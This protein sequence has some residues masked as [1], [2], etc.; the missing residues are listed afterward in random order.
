MIDR[1]GGLLAGTLLGLLAVWMLAVAALHQPAL[2]MRQVVQRSAILPPLVADLPA[3]PLMDA[4]QRFDRLPVIAGAVG[5]DLPPPDPTL[6]KRPRVAAAIRTSPRSRAAHAA[7]SSPDRA[8]S[9]AAALVATN[10]HVIAGE[11]DTEVEIDAVYWDQHVKRSRLRHAAGATLDHSP[12][13][14]DGLITDLT[15]R[16]GALIVVWGDPA[17]ALLEDVDPQRAGRDHLPLTEAVIAAV[18]SGDLAWTMVAA[19]TPGGAEALLGTPDIERMWELLTPMLRLDAPDPAAAWAEHVATLERRAQAMAAR[20]FDAL[21]FRGGG[22]DLTVGLLPGARWM[23]GGLETSMGTRTVANMPTEEVFTTPHLGRTEGVVRATRPV[24][25]TGGGL[26][27]GLELRFEGG[28]V[29]DVRR[30]ARR[31]RAARA[32]GLGPGG[33]SAWAR[34]RS[35][36]ARRGGPHRH[37]VRRLLIDE[38][39]TSHIAWGHAYAF[40]VPDLPEDA[41]AQA[42]LGF[43]RS[44]VHQDAMIG[45]SRSRSTAS[46]GRRGGAGH[47]RR[48]VGARVVA[49]DRVRPGA[50]RAGA[51]TARGESAR[52]VARPAGPGF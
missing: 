20:R 23:S 41:D 38:N 33:R 51:G 43:N 18:G 39:A 45:G 29:V 6:G 42:A 47:R 30:G 8:G 5:N 37:H 15:D 24:Q 3:G 35:S 46:S 40:T 4:L 52:A 9:C 16:R 13:W 22:T 50:G 7:S 17:P 31:G 14:W 28:R 2:G 48:P 25:L 21:R 49:V 1:A 34:S 19:P 27:D 32:A 26:V 12:A 10:A 11:S 36:T 44:A